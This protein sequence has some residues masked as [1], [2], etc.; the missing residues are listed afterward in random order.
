M[1]IQKTPG[2]VAAIASYF[3]QYGIFATEIYN[4]LLENNLQWIEFA[5]N[6]A[7]KLDDV[8]LGTDSKVIAYQVKEI[9]SS[10]F[11]YT[12][13]TQSNTESI[14][15]G[16]FKGWK[17]LK[18]QYQGKEIDARFITT[19]QVSDSDSITTFDGRSKPS[20]SKFI[21]NLWLP[22]QKGT[23]SVTTIPSAWKPVFDELVN[24]VST[25]DNELIAFI[26]DFKFVFDYNTD[27]FLYD[28]YTQAKRKSHIERIEAR[29]PQLIAKKGNTKFDRSQFLLEF[30]LKDQ[31]ETRFQHAF[32]VDDHHYLPIASTFDKLNLIIQNK[33][34]GYLAL[35]GNAGSG[36]ST[37]LTKWL[38]NSP[39][40]VLKY[41][42]YTNLDMSYD[43]GYR[44]EAKHFLHDL[45]V[46]VRENGFNMQD[47]LPEKELLDLQKHLG[48]E[49]K[50][51][52]DRRDK[53][54]IIVDG[55]DHIEREQHV[56]DSLISVLPA[57]NEIPDNIYF[58]LGSRTV[59]QLSD[60]K[61]EIRENLKSEGSTISIDSLNREQVK[62]LTDSHKLTLGAEQIENL[63]QNTKGHPLFLRYTIEELK[64]VE[65]DSYDRVI[66]SKDFSGDIYIEYGKFW[67]KYKTEDQFVHIL[68]IISRFRFPYFD[69]GLLGN[70]DINSADA[71]RI[72]KMA[73]YYFYKSDNIWQFFHNS[74]KEFLITE[75]AKNRFTRKFDKRTD[76]KFHLEIAN[77]IREIDDLYRFNIIYH[78]YKAEQFDLI[79]ELSTQSFFRDQW[80]LYRNSNILREDIR[81]ALF[82]GAQQKNYRTISAC[83]FAFLELDQR[84]SNLSFGNCYD[85]FLSADLLDIACSFV[86]DSAKL[87]L[88]NIDALDFSKMLFDKGHVE[89]A[90]E[91]FNRATPIHLLGTSTKVSKRRYD[92]QSYSELNEVALLETWANVASIFF[93]LNHVVEKCRHI[94]IEAD[95]HG[96]SDEA[97]LPGLILS[98]KDF[99]I[100]N[101]EFDKL[102]ILADLAK[103]ELDQYNQF[104][105]YFDVI[106][107]RKTTENLLQS[108]LDFFDSWQCEDN[109]SDALSY[110]LIYT[111]VNDDAAKRKKAF[112]MLVTPIELKRKRSHVRAGGLANYIFAYTRLFYIVTKDFNVDPQRFLPPTDKPIERTFDLAFANL[113]KSHAWFYHG[114]EDASVGFFSGVDSLFSIFHY[115]FNDPMYDFDIINSKVKFLQHILRVSCEMSEEITAGLLR[116]ITDE[117]TV[118]R[119][120]WSVET[121]QSIVEWCLDYDIDSKWCKTTLLGIEKEL[122]SKG[123]LNQ[124]IADGIQQARLWSRLKETP[125]V[126]SSIVKLMS[127]S[128][129]VLGEDDQQLDQMVKWI[130][131]YQP[132]PIL[133]IQY[134]LDRLVALKQNV[135]SSNHTPALEILRLSFYHGNGYQV[136]EHL[137]FN[138]LVNLLD[139][140]ESLLIY[141]LKKGWGAKK[142]LIRLFT[143]IIVALDDAHSTR[144]LF[145]NAFFKSTPQIHEIT[146]LVKELKI[147]S[148]AEIRDNYFYEIYEQITK[149]GVNPKEVGLEENTILKNNQ[150][151][152]SNSLRL[153][154]GSSLNLTDVLNKITSLDDLLALKNE[155][156]NTSYFNWTEAFIKVIPTAEAAGIDLFLSNFSLDINTEH[157]I[158]IAKVLSE[159]GKTEIASKLLK[160]TIEKSRYCQ[161]GD[162]YYAKGKIPAYDL[163][164]RLIPDD[165]V[166]TGALN[167]FVEAL[168]NMGNRERESIIADLDKVFTL[169]DKAMDS[170]L[171]Y[172]EINLYRNQLLFNE[173]SLQCVQVKGSESDD[174]LFTDFLYFLIT[175]PSQFENII[176]PVLIKDCDQLQNILLK[177]LKKLF[178]EGFTLKFLKLMHGLA[179]ITKKHIDVFK[180]ELEILIDSSRFDLVLLASEL[181]NKVGNTAQRTLQSLELPLG[182]TLELTKA[183]GIVDAS[184]KVN[185]YI[186]EEGYLKDTNDPIVYTQI[187][188][189]EIRI[190]EKV[191]GF[192]QYNIA[193]RIMAL[194]D[195]L[196]FPDWCARLTEQELRGLYESM[197]D[198]KIPYNRP[199]V[200]KVYAGLAK[201][202]MELIDL[203]Y[204]DFD[205]AKS[206]QSDFE[207]AAYLIEIVSKPPSIESILRDSGSAPAVDRK[208][209]HEFDETYISKVLTSQHGDYF[210]LAERTLMQGMGHGKAIEIREAF[211]DINTSMD[212]TDSVIFQSE[213]YVNICDYID[214]DEDGIVF[215]N[216]ARTTVFKENWLA[217][218]P[219]I[220]KSIGLRFNE[221]VGNF[222]WEN[223][224]GEV[225]IE[226]VF[227]QVGD[228]NNQSGHHDSE[229]GS[230]WLVL[231]TREGLEAVIEKLGA[232]PFFHYKRIQRN[233]EFYQR[234]YNTHINEEDMKFVVE[235][236]NLM[237]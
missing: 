167:D 43:Y 218:N 53:V 10:N 114:Y 27:Q 214:L 225:V 231:I 104:D 9:G 146:E 71:E 31:F 119:S 139:S 179:N 41:Y 208:W 77:T 11:S 56:R 8:L 136:F 188:R 217:I 89:L 44:G 180:N 235:N 38:S 39:Y 145:L 123:Y 221:N 99:L 85:I 58:I 192:D 54:F 151:G 110:A 90:R 209:A 147:F 49:L 108:G 174:E 127:I 233:L 232:P 107:K 12:Q 105:F 219:L 173:D 194:G 109:K 128:L 47:R 213:S 129:G 118:N 121:R 52:S 116:K 163:L 130:D 162:D 35:V 184:K 159:N 33:T 66:D 95:D 20:F 124:R 152:S 93:P 5:S 45:L 158:K 138:E 19:Q 237:T 141:L 120:Y 201:V 212:W 106:Y 91:L 17:S 111:F 143:R 96:E 80:F 202:M 98:L 63:F 125:L 227:W 229:S 183:F 153:K 61:Y 149:Q 204:L 36:K 160:R 25:T 148:L 6:N 59:N 215:Y 164:E 207:P 102:E 134:Y 200:Q 234:K 122:F 2:E 28:S 86:F 126:E 13:F 144:R 65:E 88:P 81:I 165:Q 195:D 73:E 224:A 55:L 205:T 84:S 193:Y 170:N 76:Q 230:G 210:V 87:L 176:Y 16:V 29:I 4:H 15:Q 189:F 26:K 177:L 175:M 50:K 1:S 82:A 133:D 115:R 211:I 62:I 220:A 198:L 57:P 187:V 156:E 83:F 186:S 113:A 185:E 155:E 100:K 206:L 112:E 199:Q 236:F 24:L 48:E 142:I 154:D 137:L 21:K 161:W 150:G 74:F 32:F 131:K 64:Q 132:T 42:A 140:F 79:S 97:L 30:D 168:P 169:F 171:I 70:F 94:V 166:S 182:Y 172:E 197:L 67:D 69:L 18:Q 37:L 68:G 7:G 223:D 46:Q 40:T 72:N 203:D 51:L 222:R 135:S 117:W 178:D 92:Q 22:I 101:K 228:S 14:F 23:Y 60:L 34:K 78:W 190:L 191:T 226:S 3:F 157:I 216:S 181:L 103:V 196:Q 75:S